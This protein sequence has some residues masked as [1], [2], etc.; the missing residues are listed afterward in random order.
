[1]CANL[2]DITE[3]C[4][5]EVGVEQVEG[6]MSCMEDKCL[7]STRNKESDFLV[8]GVWVVDEFF[9]TYLA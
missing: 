3:I 5:G 6:C 2:G 9:V 8:I 1:L 7:L 4:T